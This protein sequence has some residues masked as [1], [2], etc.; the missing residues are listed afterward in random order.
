MSDCNNM[1]CLMVETRDIM[2]KEL[3]R[4]RATYG[5]DFNSRHEAYGVILEELDESDAED[6]LF[7]EKLEHLWFEIKNDGETKEVNKL[8]TTM[9]TIAL[10]A[11]SEWIQVAAMC[12]K[13]R[14]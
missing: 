14:E 11:A 1:E 2:F 3:E 13:A 12:A 8:L 10:R 7:R 6:R 9:T 4:A 5:Y